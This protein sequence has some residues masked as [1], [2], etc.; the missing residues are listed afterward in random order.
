MAAVEKRTQDKE[1]SEVAAIRK[2]RVGKAQ[3]LENSGPCQAACSRCGYENTTRQCPAYGK[4]CAK[5]QA[6]GHFARVCRAKDRSTHMI[7][8][9]LLAS[10]S[11]EAT[12][13]S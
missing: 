7:L 12:H 4:K 2:T 6:L 11:E 1:D 9:T 10:G 3:E 8:D 5:C 13:Y